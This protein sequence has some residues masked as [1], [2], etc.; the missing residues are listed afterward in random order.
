MLDLRF[1][2]EHADL[3]R[4]GARK[5]HIAIDLDALL[6]LDEEV[7]TLSHRG[8][9]IRNLQKTR[10]KEIAALPAE[11]RS[12]AGAELTQL[13]EELRELEERLKDLRPRLNALHMQVPNVP[14][15]DVPEGRTDED[16]VERRVEGQV[17]KFDFE[18]L[19][20]V[21]LGR[22]LGLI[23]IER[24]VKVAG[25]RNYFLTGDGALLER[26][27]MNLAI[28]MMVARGF[29]LMSVPVLV[30][31]SAMEGTAYFP[32]GEEQAYTAEKDDLYL[33]GTA[34]VPLT[35]YHADEILEAADLPR[36]LVAW[37]Y[38]FRR[39]AGAAGK[40]TRGVYRI[41]QFQKVE[42]VIVGPADPVLA[43]QYHQEIMTNSEDLLK[44]LEL[45]YRVVDVCGGDLGLSQIMK[46][47][48]E[49]WMPSRG[50]YSET[51]S[52]SSFH[53]YQARRLKLRYRDAD[54]KIQFCYTLNNTVVAS[55]R[56]LI[57]LLE[58]HQQKDGTIRIPPALRPYL[59][60]RERLGG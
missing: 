58:C 32:G 31:Y 4:A 36:R 18:P 44:Q 23:D 43:R 3:V 14:A 55:P 11:Q 48:I 25:A 12:A 19:D 5:K 2:R 51:H 26:A 28:D 50:R 46:Y 52:A 38:C 47:D 27:V 45:P 35:S 40:D 16:N 37:S 49:T 54:K 42:Q 10:G 41:H 60:G 9:E 1:I 8:D 17:P 29:S 53:D 57:P 24:G 34:E 56:I 20:H 13:K 6:A 21:E 59:G 7:R 15:E 30:K 33:A 22:R 39:E